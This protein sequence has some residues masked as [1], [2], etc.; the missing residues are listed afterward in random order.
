MSIMWTMLCGGGMVLTKM[1]MMTMVMY[2]LTM[3]F[4]RYRSSKC[5]DGVCRFEASLVAMM[6]SISCCP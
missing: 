3:M 6:M 4:Q 1:S 2:T 5:V